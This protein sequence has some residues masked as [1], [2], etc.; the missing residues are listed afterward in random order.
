MARNG[1]VPRAIRS[2]ISDGE[3]G[4]E[5]PV[6]TSATNELSRTDDARPRVESV[7]GPGLLASLLGLLAL[8]ATLF[9]PLSM[10]A[11]AQE[12]QGQG[13]GQIQSQ[14]QPSLTSSWSPPRTVYLE[15]TGHT[16]DQLFLDLWRNA[17][18][19]SA[20][21]YPITAEIEQDNGHIIQYLQ[22]ARFEYWPEGD[23]NG[24]T[25]V[26]GKI[27]EELRPMS[28]QRSTAS[29]AS[30][31]SSEGSGSVVE[32]VRFSQ[33]WLPITKRSVA[34][35]SGSVRYIDTTRHSIRDGFLDFWERSGG[36]AYLGNP[37][38]EEYTLGGVTYQIFERG[39]LA[40]ESSGDVYMTPVG[41][42]L[43]E[44]Y[45]LDQEPVPQGDIPTYSEELFVPPPEPT[46]TPVPGPA[47]VAQSAGYQPGGG[48]VWL[49]VNLSTQYMIV[50]QGSTPILETYVSTGKPGFDTPPGSYRINTKIEVQDMEGVLGGEYYN[51]PSV[52]WVM[53]FTDVGHAIHG[54]YW[55]DNFGAVM[56]HGC[57][58]LPVD[59]AEYLYGITPIG[60]R[61][62]IHW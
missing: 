10:P 59:F 54:A 57:V 29:F 14:D 61:V 62:E 60:A 6:R 51:V 21:G 23:A 8:V 17:G 26:L 39:Q 44:K 43:A 31:G 9:A 16:L 19:A 18:G 4:R 37:L 32:S 2:E 46:P 5:T 25:V 41:R 47:E 56:S 13:Q 7:R 28:V 30:K 53:Y 35:E 48:E 42:M 22:Y 3:Q 36:D 50:Y 34:F 33:A 52:P 12:Q 58:N 55:H 45:G 24:N 11:S 40:L 15:E 1:C 38:T 49:D 20:F 27:G